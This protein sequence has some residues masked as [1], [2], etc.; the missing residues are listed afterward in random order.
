MRNQQSSL[1]FFGDKNH[2]KIMYSNDTCLTVAIN[3]LIISEGLF[4][5]FPQKPRFKNVLDFKINVSNVSNPPNR[6][7]IAEDILDVIC[8]QNM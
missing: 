4:F 6:N 1:L 7:V 5:N 3:D 8:D 2:Q